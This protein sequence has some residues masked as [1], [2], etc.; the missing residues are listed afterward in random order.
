MLLIR[1]TAGYFTKNSIAE[2]M[3]PLANALLLCN[4]THNFSLFVT[5]IK[6]TL[7]SSYTFFAISLMSR[8]LRNTTL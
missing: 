1:Q 7:C 2:A 6:H 4:P 5:P 8:F 3:Q